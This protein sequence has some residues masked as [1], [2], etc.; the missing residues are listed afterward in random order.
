MRKPGALHHARF[1]ASCL[2]LLKL[3]MLA[4]ALP[5][6]MMTPNQR[7]GVDRLAQYVALFHAPYFLQALLSPSAPRLDLAL[8]R[9]MTEYNAIDARISTAVKSSIKRQQ[10]YLTQVHIYM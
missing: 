4:D 7:T 1:L 6:G 9:D 3:S 10:W 5:R 8:W 2:Y